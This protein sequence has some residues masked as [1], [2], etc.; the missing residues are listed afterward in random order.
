[1]AISQF[2]HEKGAQAPVQYCL[3]GCQQAEDEFNQ[4]LNTVAVFKESKCF[5]PKF[6]EETKRLTKDN[7]IPREHG[8]KRARKSQATGSDTYTARSNPRTIGG[9]ISHPV[10]PC[11]SGTCRPDAA[12][13]SW[14]L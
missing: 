5:C 10:F 1:M 14:V 13:F 6:Y 3:N 2:A 4:A 9:P 8:D 11:A 7:N 12:G